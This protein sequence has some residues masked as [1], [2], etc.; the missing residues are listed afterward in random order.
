MADFVASDVLLTSRSLKNSRESAKLKI[1]SSIHK[2]RETALPESWIKTQKAR[3]I[4]F[5]TWFERFTE[6]TGDDYMTSLGVGACGATGF[7]PTRMLI[8]QRSLCAFNQ[9]RVKLQ[10]FLFLS[11]FLFTLQVK[12]HANI[13]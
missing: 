5:H 13:S 3:Q 11:C 2:P 1:I 10:L 9:K 4:S 6:V 8:T 12:P 7:C